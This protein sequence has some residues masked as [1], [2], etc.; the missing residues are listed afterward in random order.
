MAL[1]KTGLTVA[2]LAVTGY[3]RVL[4]RRVSAERSVPVADGTT[5]SESTPREVS[6]AQKQLA[7]LQWAVPT[8]TGALI[9]VSA[10]AGEQQRPMSVLKGLT[11]RVAG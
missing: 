7:A 9:V 6:S 1:V 5:P 2:A 3:S 8:L 10:F 11:K 4:G